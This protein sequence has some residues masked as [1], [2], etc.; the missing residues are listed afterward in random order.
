MLFPFWSVK[1][2]IYLPL[3]FRSRFSVSEGGFR[4]PKSFFGFRSRF[5]KYIDA[6]EFGFDLRLTSKW[7]HFFPARMITWLTVVSLA[8]TQKANPR[9]LWIKNVLIAN[10]VFP[11]HRVTLSR[12]PFFVRR[13]I[14]HSST[15]DGLVASHGLEPRESTTTTTAGRRRGKP[16]GRHGWLLFWKHSTQ[17]GKWRKSGLSWR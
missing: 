15:T 17:F 3:S 1:P 16:R 4:F 7:V 14:S 2:G 13:R 6:E 9:D 8:M 10:F 5:S 12:S 11:P